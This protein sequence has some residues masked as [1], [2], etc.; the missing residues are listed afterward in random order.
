[1][2]LRAIFKRLKKK[3]DNLARLIKEKRELKSITSDKKRSY[4]KYYR[5]IEDHKRLP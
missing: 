4:N 5:H 2:K 1:M 3:K